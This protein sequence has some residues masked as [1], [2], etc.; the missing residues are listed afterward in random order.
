M[1]SVNMGLDPYIFGPEYSAEEINSHQHLII[2]TTVQPT[3]F[4]C[5]SPSFFRTLTSH[6]KYYFGFLPKIYV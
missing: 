4:F 5:K 6:L 2:E 3:P 1:E